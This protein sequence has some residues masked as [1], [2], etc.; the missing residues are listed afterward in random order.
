MPNNRHAKYCQM[1]IILFVN[2]DIEANLAYNLLKKE[3][4]HHNVNI[5][6]SESVGG[7]KYKPKEL[8]QIE[9]YEK[10]YFFGD[11]V[12]AIRTN[13]IHTN[14]EFFNEDFS[15]FKM[16]KCTNVNDS[17]FI[18]DIRQL[19]PD[20]FISL[21]FGKIFKDEIIDVPKQG[22]LN[23]HS[24]ILP[25]YKGIMG[26][27]HNLKDQKAE[28]GCT[29]H[30]I[31]SST[32]DTGQIISIAKRKVDKER[33]L[34][35]HIIQLYPEG[36][37]LILDSIDLLNTTTRLPAVQQDKT[38]GN[39]Y[40]VPTDQDFQILHD[41][42]IRSFHFEDYKEIVSEYISDQLLTTLITNKPLGDWHA[43]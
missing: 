35:W 33:S 19:E 11:L 12:R 36:C 23:L 17:K 32:I 10:D 18:D 20:I 7:K 25:D 39:Y 28:Y 8:R 27:L 9:Y 5:F 38:E 4:L 43:E 6:Y 26:T 2:K 16:S 1:N 15:S 22:I 34:F 42:N 3:L 14:F 31:D 30:Y 13:D 37:D 21:R 29:L 41:I 24:A 40:S